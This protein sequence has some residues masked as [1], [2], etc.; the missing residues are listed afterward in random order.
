MHKGPWTIAWTRAAA[1][2]P[3]TTGPHYLSQVH[4][5]RW[6]STALLFPQGW[7][8]HHEGTEQGTEAVTHSCLSFPRTWALHTERQFSQEDRGS[9]PS[10]RKLAM[11]KSVSLMLDVRGGQMPPGC[12]V[13]KLCH[14]TR[15][16]V[17]P[18]SGPVSL[19][20]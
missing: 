2:G 10:V 12:R 15:H 5:D 7:Y 14:R 18:S 8:M 1:S 9:L 17:G 19:C 20:V 4:W 16:L 13:T 3:P 6:H 11:T